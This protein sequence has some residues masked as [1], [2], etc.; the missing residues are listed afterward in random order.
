[1]VNE[2]SYDTVARFYDLEYSERPEENRFFIE[3]A[4]NLGPPVLELGCG[5]GKVLIPLA[6]SGV[7]IWGLDP[8]EGMLNAARKKIKLLDKEVASRITLTKGDMRNFSM[9]KRFNLTIIPFCSFQLLATTEDQEKALRCIHRHL[10]RKGLLIVDLVSPQLLAKAKNIVKEI[11]DEKGGKIKITQWGEDDL[12][13]NPPVMHI[14]RTYEETQNNG[15][16]KI[17]SWQETI[18]YIAKEE[19]EHLLI[20]EGFKVLNVYRDFNKERYDAQIASE[21]YFIA[22]LKC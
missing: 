4:D 5:T 15:S 21:M 17:T 19:M 11:V 20:S 12:S 22:K 14:H 1:M 13:R 16:I 8:S 6:K 7:E 3:Y 2:E 9:P 10:T 18:C